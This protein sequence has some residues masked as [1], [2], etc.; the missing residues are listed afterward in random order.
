MDFTIPFAYYNKHRFYHNQKHIQKMLNLFNE[1]FYDVFTSDIYRNVFALSICYHDYIYDP[2]KN[3]NEELSFEAFKKEARNLNINDDDIDFGKKLIMCTKTLAPEDDYEKLFLYLDWSI[4]D[5]SVSSYTDISAYNYGI[6]KE[7]QC[8]NYK[9]FKKGRLEFLKTVSSKF[10]T[11]F[12]DCQFL[13]KDT[14]NRMLIG[15]EFAIRDVEAFKPSI[16]VYAGSF[17]P[18]HAGHFN[19]LE[20]AERMFDKVVIVQAKNPEKNCDQEELPVTISNREIVKSDGFICDIL[21]SIK[22][23]DESHF[24]IVRGI[25]TGQDLIAEQA[26]QET[27]NDLGC[28]DVFCFVLCDSKY[29]HISSTMIRGAAKLG[30]KS[31]D[32][33]ID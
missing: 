21:N 16:G 15:L 19:V 5:I 28:N 7:F 14:I 8:Y 33:F 17:N 20:K 1:K 9:D 4:F 27:L 30:L 25:R 32:W 18:F 12:G 2:S 6:F 26:Y 10:E 24:S 13:N 23:G 3:N 11:M 31:K 29:Q 22:S